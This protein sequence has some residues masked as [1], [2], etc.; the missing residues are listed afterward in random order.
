MYDGNGSACASA[1]ELRPIAAA[2][3]L[4][5]RVAVESHLCLPLQWQ[6]LGTRK[7][8]PKRSASALLLN[9]L[10][11]Y[12]KMCKL[13]TPARQAVRVNSNNHAHQNAYQYDCGDNA[14]EHWRGDWEKGIMSPR[15]HRWVE[16]SDSRYFSR[17]MAPKRRGCLGL[18]FVLPFSELVRHFRDFTA[19]WRVRSRS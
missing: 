16:Y 19:S 14:Q 9:R 15:G 4:T 13:C 11:G 3:L 10:R 1:G 5:T 12:S 18:E 2:I 6:G 17:R 8:R 7:L